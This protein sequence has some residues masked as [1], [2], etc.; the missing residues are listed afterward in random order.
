MKK[1]LLFEEY[2]NQF[3]SD[4]L[5]EAS[6]ED[7][8][9]AAILGSTDKQNLGDSASKIGIEKNVSYTISIKS[10]QD[11]ISLGTNKTFEGF[12][13]LEKGSA[14]GDKVDFITIT[15]KGQTKEIP[16][17]V[18][19]SGNIILDFDNSEIKVNASNNGLL[20]FMRACTAAS[21]VFGKGG[22]NPQ[23]V[24]GKLLISMGNPITEDSSRNAAFLAV[25]NDIT[26]SNDNLRISKSE[27]DNTW[28][29]RIESSPGKVVA[30]L[31]ESTSTDL[32]SEYVFE[33][34]SMEDGSSLIKL[35]GD[36]LA[37]SIR[38]AA[39]QYDK[40]NQTT[41]PNNSGAYAS[42]KKLYQKIGSIEEVKQSKPSPKTMSPVVLA[43][44][45]E[46]CIKNLSYG[47]PMK[48]VNANTIGAAKDILAKVGNSKATNLDHKPLESLLSQY[49]PDT[50]ESIPQFNP[51]LGD[52]WKSIT[53]A[54]VLRSAMTFSKNASTPLSPAQEVEGKKVKGE[55]K[56]GSKQ[57]VSGGV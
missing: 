20:A 30:A 2:L 3:F 46:I 38:A 33:Q 24:K 37:D 57:N 42:F 48:K 31:K 53:S 50:Y 56:S 28:I 18:A 21:E 34:E 12:S 5:N 44:L 55:E 54:V 11:L 13:G 45:M 51:I 47:Y 16:Q 49:K 26:G 9:F 10:I 52:F 39:F 27:Y 35:V 17:K 43:M 32:E 25:S 41:F 1:V 19:A 8:G 4:V 36:S 40:P 29:P 7:L 23:K 15:S 14:V 22:V 6:M